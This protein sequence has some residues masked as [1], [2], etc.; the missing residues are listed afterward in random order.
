M[1]RDLSKITTTRK[2]Q[3]P[4]LS[5]MGTKDYAVNHWALLL[6]STAAWTVMEE[7]HIIVKMGNILISSIG[8]LVKQI[9]L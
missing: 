1:L 4:N 7:L 6:K 5:L 9:M 3:D 2:W 8:D